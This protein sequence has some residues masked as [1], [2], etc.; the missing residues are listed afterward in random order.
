MKFQP[1]MNYLV[2]NFRTIVGTPSPVGFYNL[3]NPVL[4][5][6]AARLGCA[7]TYDRRGTPYITLEG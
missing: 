5:E 4:E 3:L 6:E 1:D 2:E 7:V